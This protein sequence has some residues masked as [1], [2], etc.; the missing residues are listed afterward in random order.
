MDYTEYNKNS[1]AFE[2]EEAASHLQDLAK[3]V[4]AGEYDDCG[5]LAYFVGLKHVFEHLNRSWNNRNRTDSDQT[6]EAFHIFR[7][8]SLNIPNIDGDFYLAHGYSFSP[9]PPT[10]S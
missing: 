1:V 7:E 8:A 10:I 6:A 3:E 2:L 9:R 4:L 5:D